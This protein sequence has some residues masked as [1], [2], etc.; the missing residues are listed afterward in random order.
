MGPPHPSAPSSTPGPLSIPARTPL[1]SGTI[2]GT[3]RTAEPCAPP[4]PSLQQPPQP[5]PAAQAPL[6]ASSAEARDRPAQRSCDR[7]SEGAA[8][9]STA[10]AGR[11][12]ADVPPLRGRMSPFSQGAR[13]RADP[14]LSPLRCAALGSRDRQQSP[15]T[16]TAPGQAVRAGG[17]PPGGTEA[18]PPGGDMVSLDGPVSLAL[19]GW[20]GG[21][22][23]VA[24]RAGSAALRTTAP[25]A[26]NRP[27]SGSVHSP[28]TGKGSQGLPVPPLTP[29]SPP[30]PAAEEGGRARGAWAS[31]APGTQG[32]RSPGT[33]TGWW[34]SSPAG[35]TTGPRRSERPKR[36]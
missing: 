33:R 17:Q 27:R 22:C 29:P 15:K 11:D 12:M 13:A 5:G 19:P 14:P 10:G 9:G 3:A 34:R 20:A 21:G 30:T 32:Q 35:W 16:I 18:A 6:G 25:C 1:S 8:A 31:P 28:G 26:G 4:Q 36:T 23:G 2:Q 7:G 24:G